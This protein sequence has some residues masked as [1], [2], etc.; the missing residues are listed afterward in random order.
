L[1]G[2]DVREIVNDP[3]SAVLN[4]GTSVALVD[5]Q[6]EPKTAAQPTSTQEIASSAIPEW[7]GS[8]DAST[9]MIA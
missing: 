4:Q 7:P 1:L 2:C 3:I 6:H 9:N 8:P 5:P